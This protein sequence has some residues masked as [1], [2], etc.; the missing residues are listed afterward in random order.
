[1]KKNLFI[2]VFFVWFFLMTAIHA[3]PQTAINYD[4]SLP[5]PSAGLDMKFSTKGFLP[6]RM[7][8]AQ[9]IAI[10]NPV[11]G[12][13][14][15]CTDCGPTATGSLVMF[16]NGAWYMLNSDC[17]TTPSA[18]V[19]G[20]SVPS[21][22]QITWNWNT[23]YGAIGYKWNTVN[24]FATAIEMGSAT[25]K[26]ETGLTCGTPYIRYVWA[27]NSCG[28]SQPMVLS[29]STLTCVTCLPITDPRDGKNYNTVLIGTQC[30]MAQN[31]NVGTR[32]NGSV[33]QT[34]NGTVEKHCYSDNEANCT[35]YGGL[36][37]WNEM[38][39]YTTTSNSNPSGRQGICPTGWHV[40]SDAE[41]CQM[42]IFLDPTVI[43]TNSGNLGTNIGGMLKETGTI[44]WSS[45]NVGA[46]NSSGFT[47]LPGGYRSGGFSYLTTGADFWT[48][49]EYTTSN[50]YDYFLGYGSSQISKSIDPKTDSYSCRC[51]KD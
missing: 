32:I 46:T 38:M 28:N 2:P 9:V 8:Y 5:D 30:W 26:M 23:V 4:G 16:M 34:N 18:P 1:M 43:C 24:N 31:L 13:Y 14:L 35:I 29:Q 42:E 20:N 25:T 10:T 17:L 33:N 44:H 45:P 39:N 19:A 7:T 12:L 27:Y 36:Y 51:V 21:L 49:T 15:F 37:Q 50:G 11:S 41:W 47:A 40:P 3:F 22:T 48:T 6:P